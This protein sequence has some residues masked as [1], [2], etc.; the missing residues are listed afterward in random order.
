MMYI[1]FEA[2]RRKTGE[3]LLRALVSKLQTQKTI[4]KAK[5]G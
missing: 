4:L 2:R 5:C 3:I 1:W